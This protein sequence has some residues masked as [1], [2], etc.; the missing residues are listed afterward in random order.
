MNTSEDIFAS[1]ESEKVLIIGNGFDLS[2]G[3]NTRY[4]DFVQSDYWKTIQEEYFFAYL[5]KCRQ[6]ETW[7]D[8]EEILGKYEKSMGNVRPILFNSKNYWPNANND[9]TF[10]FMLCDG[11]KCYLGEEQRKN[12]SQ[13]SVAA[14]ILNAIAEN[15]F[16][17]KVYTFNYT[18]LALLAGKLQIDLN[19]LEIEHI[20]GNLN[21]GIV[22]GV[23]ETV[24]LSINYDFLYKTSNVFYGSHPLP[25]SL[26]R[27]SEVVIFGHSMSDNDYF[28]FKEFFEKQSSTGL[29]CKDGKQITFFT[30]DENSRLS[31]V[32]QLRKHLKGRLTQLFARNKIQIIKTD[33]SDDARIAKYIQKLQET[34]LVNSIRLD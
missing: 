16:F 8:L 23:P 25:Y 33:G 4:C 1:D 20:H 5:N 2:L 24:E 7:F 18:N 21:E 14:K 26:N 30:Y 13:E 17:Q 15:G 10:F 12:L 31:I 29:S 27:A 11:L 32:R 28:Y 3:L 19:G 9:K 34:S 6:T 22:L